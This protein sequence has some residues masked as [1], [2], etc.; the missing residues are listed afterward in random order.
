MLTALLR[1][2]W[3]PTLYPSDTFG[4]VLPSWVEFDG[5]TGNVAD[6]EAAAM[7]NVLF[8]SLHRRHQLLNL[9]SRRP[10]TST[11]IH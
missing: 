4:D 9:P 1:E 7:V 8:G 10:P 2:P 5:V 6:D 3:Q 11:D